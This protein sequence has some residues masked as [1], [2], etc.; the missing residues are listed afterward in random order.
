MGRYALVN[1]NIVTSVLDIDESDLSRYSAVN[2]MIIDVTNIV[3]EP[4][5]GFVLNGN[6]LEL[7]QG[8]S[9]REQFEIDLAIKKMDFGANLARQAIAK[10]GARNKILNKT[11]EQVS[12]LLTQLLSVKLLL[13]TGALGTARGACMQLQAVFTEYADIF[14]DVIVEINTFESSFG[15]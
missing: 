11:G 12:A 1:N 2:H 13:E 4:R 5:I 3:P 9:S 14:A 8:Q 15:L 6:V 10:I 7:P